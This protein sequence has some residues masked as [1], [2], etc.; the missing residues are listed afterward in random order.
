[1]AC[2]SWQH[3]SIHMMLLPDTIPGSSLCPDAWV[4]QAAQA[5]HLYTTQLGR[6]T[7][8]LCSCSCD[9]VSARAIRVHTHHMACLV[10]RLQ[11]Y[12][13]LDSS[14]SSSRH[15]CTSMHWVVILHACWW[16]LHNAAH[17]HAHEQ[18]SSAGE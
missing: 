12:I 7:P 15:Q 10:V 16:Q 8:R 18:T 2:L 6:A 3:Q 13:F 1:M 9:M 5:T 4:L 17:K 11:A 14:P